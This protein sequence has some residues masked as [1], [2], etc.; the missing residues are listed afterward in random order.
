MRPPLSNSWS[1][2]RSTLGW[3]V[4]SFSKAVPERACAVDRVGRAAEAVRA[5]TPV[6][7]LQTGLVTRGS[8]MMGTRPTGREKGSELK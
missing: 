6:A 8:A 7:V 3:L 1:T 2:R 5:R 4:P